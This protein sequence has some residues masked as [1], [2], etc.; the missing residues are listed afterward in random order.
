MTCNDCIHYEACRSQVPRTFYDSKDFYDNCKWFKEK[1]RYIELPFNV[2]DKLYT[3]IC[4]GIGNWEIRESVIFKIQKRL[5]FQ[6]EVIERVKDEKGCYSYFP[7]NL[8]NLGVT[9]FLT[10]EDA[11]QKLQRS[12]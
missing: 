10:R 3:A 2:E 6:L 9:I 7:I 4:Y 12:N 8:E 5:G 1:S 11:E